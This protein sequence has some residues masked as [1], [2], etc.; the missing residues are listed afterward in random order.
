MSPFSLPTFRSKALA[1]AGT[2]ALAL[3]VAAPAFAGDTDD[4]SVRVQAEIAQDM[5]VNG[6]EDIDLGLLPQGFTAVAEADGSTEFDPAHFE[7]TGP[8]VEWELEA[9]FNA[10]EHDIDGDTHTLEFVEGDSGEI[11]FNF[12]QGDTDACN[13]LEDSGFEF[14]ATE[15]G[16]DGEGLAAVGYALEVDDDQE[17]G[18]YGGDDDGDHIVLTATAQLSSE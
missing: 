10:L 6:V 3:G 1:F 16:A 9:E 2:S 8:S 4:D 11:C 17:E 7:V 12:D 5:V 15:T 18:N 13:Q 14:D